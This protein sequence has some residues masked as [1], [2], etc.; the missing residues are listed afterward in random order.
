M[1]TKRSL[2]AWL[3]ITVM[4]LSAFSACDTSEETTTDSAEE[5]TEK[6]TETESASEKETDA[7]TES[8][9]A[10]EVKTES[11]TVA[12]TATETEGETEEPLETTPLTLEDPIDLFPDYK[13]YEN[14][15]SENKAPAAYVPFDQRFEA[16]D[17]DA[18]SC[19]IQ[20][21][22]TETSEEYSGG[23]LIRLLS[24]PD[25]GWDFV[26]SVSYKVTVPTEGNYKMT[27]LTSDLSRDYTSD[28]FIDVN[29]ERQIDAAKT[30][31]RIEDINYSI[32]KGLYF[33]FDLGSLTL[34]EGENVVTFVI[35]NE[36][37]QASQNRLSFCIDYF[38][39]T[40]IK[41]EALEA[42]TPA[43]ITLDADLSE[44][45]DSSIISGAA[46]VHVFD[47]RFPIKLNFN[48]YFIEDGEMPYTITDYFGKVVYSGTLKGAAYDHI[49]VERTIKN[50]PTGYFVFKCGEEE[51]AYVVTPSFE[52]RTLEDSPFAMDYAS[53][54]HNRELTNCFNVSAAA[55][56]A[57]VTWVRDRASWGSYES[58]PGV[59]N[60]TVTEN[61]FRTIDKSGLKLLVDLCPAPSWA[62]K[63]AGYT[64]T[65][66]VGGF[67]NNQLAFYHMCKAMVEYY[68]G[69]V[70]AW[71]LWNE[72]DHGFA[73]ET[74]ELFSAWY[75]AGALGVYDADPEMIVSFGGFC[76]P[77]S[78]S[79][80][81][82]LTMLNDILEYSTIYNYHSHVLQPSQLTYQ[83][84]I[85]TMAKTAF[86]TAALYNEVARPV[87]ISEA[88][89]RNDGMTYE[90]YISQANFIVTSTVESLSIG[91]DKHFW[92]LLA[93][94]MENSGDFGTFSP[95]LEPY[96]TLAAEAAM[97]EVL[98]KAQYLGTLGDIPSKSSAYVFNTG[99]RIASVIWTI[100][101][102]TKYTFSAT[103]PVIVTDMMGNK[104][105]VEPVDGKIT[106]EIGEHP[107]FIT[108][109][110][111][112][113]YLPQKYD[114]SKLEPLTFTAGQRV[115]LSAEFENYD[116]NNPKTKLNGH[117]IADG[118]VIKV[119]V[120]NYNSFAVTGT[121]DAALIGFEVLGTDTEITVEPYAEAYVTLTLKKT[122]DE[123]VNDYI[124]FTGT[125]N[126]EQ[127][128]N[129]TA[130]VFTEETTASG[131]FT[132][133]GI[134]DN[135]TAK[136]KRL[137]S[138]QAIVTDL[139][140]T[141][142]VMLNEE[143]IDTF[144]FEDNTFDI[145]L[146]GIEPGKYT[147]IVA[148]ESAGGDY[149]FKHV[150]IQYDG[151]KVVFDLP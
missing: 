85:A 146:S 118:S 71:E 50:H 88:G 133:V 49:T 110:V 139:T 26:Y 56:L 109:S 89:M 62:T 150:F 9:S 122:G 31:Q 131:Y 67:Q 35:D 77:N 25:K 65:S 149:S 29:G 59:Y 15:S 78:N 36:D 18:D 79:D 132:W 135:S 55:R 124:T 16:E 28:Y 114:D 107:I 11:E 100:R 121:V 7:K 73:V 12:E 87:W 104:T 111:A 103:L 94:Y 66:R 21:T 101:G 144:T 37:S 17:Y 113:N 129:A 3:L 33:V 10:T 52:T 4:L 98:G 136:A 99:K 8:E 90:S 117:Q 75:K 84:F 40:A 64:G 13:E 54:M 70:D 20:W 128:S 32:D 30:G 46:Q 72:S 141:P 126:G 83:T 148:M 143:F 142:H 93:P 97:T 119:R 51:Q 45:K 105:L 96:P 6:L 60:F 39:L 63:D 22:S 68:D 27:A 81:V 95:E 43:T 86:L 19:T 151:S 58:K 130:H 147:L 61:I 76:Q 47:Q 1:K 123:V 138:I 5:T 42:K 120:T 23:A 145:D 38:T 134:K 137:E 44:V 41:P 48:H 53:S 24:K 34:K 127:T 2:I 82:H 80:Y 116:I 69:V 115:V 106:V 74:A 14:Q 91:T 112:P 102:S 92:F 140:G 57:G 125:F 108:Y